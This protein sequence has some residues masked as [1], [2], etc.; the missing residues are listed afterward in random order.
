VVAGG[1]V[2]ASASSVPPSIAWKLRLRFAVSGEGEGVA[3][4]VGFRGRLDAGRRAGSS[5]RRG[6]LLGPLALQLHADRVVGGI[7][8]GIHAALGRCVA[9][10]LDRQPRGGRQS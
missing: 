1:S 4:T 5:R 3:C 6:V 7:H 10:E 2:S 9:G 8:G